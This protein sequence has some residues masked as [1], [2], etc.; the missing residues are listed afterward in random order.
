M[1]TGDASPARHADR[2]YDFDTNSLARAGPERMAFSS[3]IMVAK[4]AEYDGET[5]WER[6]LSVADR[7]RK[8]ESFTRGIV[9]VASSTAWSVTGLLA[10]VEVMVK[11]A[12][13]LR[14]NVMSFMLT[15]CRGV[16]CRNTVSCD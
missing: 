4:L 2:S 12:M 13:Q 1:R 15:C 8:C 9:V 3:P 11:K 10:I 5:K 6:H 14:S 7:C 16:R